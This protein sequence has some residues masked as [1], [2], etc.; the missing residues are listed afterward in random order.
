MGNRR[1]FELSEG[2]R[3]CLD[4]T[5]LPWEALRCDN[6]LWLLIHEFAVPEGYNVSRATV[7]LLIEPSYPE[8]ELDMAYFFPALL[9]ENK[10]QIGGLSDHPLDGKSFQRWS[11]HRPKGEWRPDIDNVGTHLLQ[12]RAWLLREVT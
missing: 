7:A 4:S 3:G 8:T 10:K 12:V 2:D 11:R 5:G 9:P 6:K 1:E